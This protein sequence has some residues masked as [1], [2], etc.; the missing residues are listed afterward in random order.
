MS[1][2]SLVASSDSNYWQKK[3]KYQVWPVW[4]KEQKK[5]PHLFLP[6]CNF[7][8]PLS[9]VFSM[10]HFSSLHF[11]FKVCPSPSIHNEKTGLSQAIFCLH[12]L[13]FLIELVS[14]FSFYLINQ[15]SCN[16]ITISVQ[17]LYFNHHLSQGIEA[18][19]KKSY[20]KINKFFNWKKC[21]Y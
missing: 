3:D 1:I 18:F 5:I 16:K 12:Y 11:L 17:K 2:P 14:F 7:S 9:Q 4:T 19:Q 15:N 6:L 10:Y 13:I 21:M 8:L 20:R